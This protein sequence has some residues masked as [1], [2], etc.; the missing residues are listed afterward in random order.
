MDMESSIM[1]KG[2]NMQG[3]GLKTKCREEE[4]SIMQVSKLLT[5]DSGKVTNFMDMVYFTTKC[6]HIFKMNLITN[7]CTW[8]I[9]IG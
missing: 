5:K 4:R 2:E 7:I 9:I 1:Q 8:L 6:P 3:S